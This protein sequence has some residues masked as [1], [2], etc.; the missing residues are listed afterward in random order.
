MK[1]NFLPLL[2]MALSLNL[3]AQAPTLTIKDFPYQKVD[4]TIDYAATNTLVAKPKPGTG[5]IY[6]FS[7]ISLGSPLNFEFTAFS[8]P[9][10]PTLTHVDF[11]YFENITPALGIDYDDLLGL[12]NNG[13]QIIGKHYPKQSYGIGGL[14]GA[15]T[16]SFLMK[17]QFLIY[18]NPVNILKFPMTMGNNW[19]SDATREFNASLTIGA[20]GVK[21]ANFV[22]RTRETRKDSVVG[23]GDVI[24]PIG[25]KPSEAFRNLMVHRYIT[26][27]DSFY[28]DGKPAPTALLQ[29]FSLVQ[30]KQSDFSR[31]L[32][33]RAKELYPT[34][35]FR[36]NSS[37]LTNFTNFAVNLH[38]GTVGVFNN[39]AL[40]IAPNPTTDN[41]FRFTPNKSE[42]MTLTISDVSGKIIISSDLE[43]SSDVVNVAL[44]A[45][46]QSGMYIIRVD[47]NISK[48][49]DVGKLMVR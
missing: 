25:G 8:D 7:K 10:L 19:T 41:R 1:S 27:V 30:G 44:P 33:W 14:T 39:L 48:T 11:G 49:S 38:G 2:F 23:W 5:Q 42:P 26:A 18:K 15:A 17:E 43:A 16:D 20:Y 36:Y 45:S 6:D 47:Y 35:I 46:T 29:A 4:V 40:Q 28:L 31:I 34:A 24:V 12:N 37:N 9:Q 22:K 13:F 3:F 21:N 32:F